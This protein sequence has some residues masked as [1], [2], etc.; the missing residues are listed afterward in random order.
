[1]DRL[2]F[3][4]EDS[5]RRDSGYE[6]VQRW[7]RRLRCKDV[8]GKLCKREAFPRL[9]SIHALRVNV[10]KTLYCR[11]K[12]LSEIKHHYAW[13]FPKFRDGKDLR[14]VLSSL[15]CSSSSIFS[16]FSFLQA[17]YCCKSLRYRCRRTSSNRRTP[18]MR[19]EQSS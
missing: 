13:T 4:H 11:I 15:V 6:S 10:F 2:F 12:F 3:E 7:I 5:E 8:S 16:Y 1:V 9:H 19:L 17:I 18:Y 14:K